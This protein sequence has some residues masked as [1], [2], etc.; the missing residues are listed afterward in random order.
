VAGDT[1]AGSV[2]EWWKKLDD[3]SKKFLMTIGAIL[4]AWRLLNLR[5]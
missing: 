3:G 2:I 5:S 4:I 1:G